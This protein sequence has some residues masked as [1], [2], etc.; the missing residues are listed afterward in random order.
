MAGSMPGDLEMIERRGYWEARYLGTYAAARYKKL[1]AAS[2]RACEENRGSLLL[3]DIRALQD[4]T[5]TTHE[6]FEFGRYGAE[7]S[8]NLARVSILAS[9][10][11]LNPDAFSTLVAQNRGLRIRA[12]TDPKA[13]V[14]WL[15][16]G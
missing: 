7:I 15:L 4:F 8:R 11:Q 2:V 10:E 9:A 14:E 6:R 13:A 5:P 16:K 12:F 1:M 3:V